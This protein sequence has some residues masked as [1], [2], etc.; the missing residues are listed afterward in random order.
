MKILQYIL[1]GLIFI[2]TTTFGQR[3]QIL[4]EGCICVDSSSVDQSLNWYALIK[5]ESR[6][7]YILKPVKIKLSSKNDCELTTWKI[8]TNIKSKSLYLIGTN[9]K[10]SETQIYAPY[11]WENWSGVDITKTDMDIY[12]IDLVDEKKSTSNQ[13]YKF[14]ENEFGGFAIIGQTSEGQKVAQELHR[15][16][17]IEILKRNGLFLKWFGDIDGDKKTDLILRASTDGERGSFTYLFLSSEAKANEVIRKAAET[18]IGHC[19]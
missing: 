7:H 11:N 8:D 13:L 4:H 3:S 6:F 12:S 9:H 18:N 10:W 5:T 2:S 17:D 16:F 1:I 19:N 15:D 14:G